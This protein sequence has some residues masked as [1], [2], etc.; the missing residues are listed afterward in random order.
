MHFL[1]EAE[2]ENSPHDCVR[3]NADVLLVV[4]QGDR[5]AGRHGL[6]PRYMRGAQHEVSASALRATPT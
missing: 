5:D 4:V 2:R 3:G 6:R 1:V